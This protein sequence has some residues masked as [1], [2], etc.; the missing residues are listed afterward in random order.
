MKLYHVHRENKYDELF[1]E[2]NV[3]FIINNYTCYN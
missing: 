1:K 3:S 2:G